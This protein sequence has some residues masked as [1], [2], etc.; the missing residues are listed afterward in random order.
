[1][2]AESVYTERWKGIGGT[3]WAETMLISFSKNCFYIM[4]VF[5][6]HIQWEKKRVEFS[7][8]LWPRIGTLENIF[9]GCKSNHNVQKCIKCG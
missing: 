7:S 5:Y 6:S 3:F 1:M 4:Y 9:I 8:S 2:C